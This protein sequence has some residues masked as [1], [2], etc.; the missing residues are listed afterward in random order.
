MKRNTWI[1]LA[2]FAAL[3]GLWA[4]KNHKTAPKSPPALSID[5]YIGNVSEQD[6][7]TQAKDKPSPVTHIEIARKDDKV[8]LDRLQV[9]KPQEPQQG[10][11]PAVPAVEAKWKVVRTY[12][13][14]TTETTA[15][16]FR[17]QSM[18]ETLQRSIRSTYG[19]PVQAAQLADYGLD[20]DHALVLTL[21]LAD[22]KIALKIG[23]LDK[24]QDVDS[25]VTWVQDPARPD[26]AY[27][28]VGRDLRTSFDVTWS[29]LRDRT[30]L[31]LEPAAVD[32]LEIHN[33]ADSQAKSVVV[34]RLGLTDD[35]KKALAEGKPAREPG[36]GWAWQ[37]PAGFQVGE[38][39]EWLKAVDRMS[40]EEFLD[41]ADVLE[42]K[43]DTGLTD[44]AIAVRLVIGIAGQN[45]EVVLG[46]KDEKGRYFGQVKGRDEVMLLPAY[47]R[48]QVVQTVAQLR[49][50]RA[51]AS[52]K[53]ADVTGFSLIGADGEIH[54]ELQGKSW[55]VGKVAVVDDKAV[56][57]YLTDLEGIKV[58]FAEPATPSAVGV[59]PP[60]L[61]VD[62]QSHNGPIRLDFGKEIDNNTWG[63]RTMA[64]RTEWFKVASWGIKRLQKKSEDFADKH[65]SAIVVDK[66]SEIWVSSA[67]GQTTHARKDE[68]GAWQLQDALAGKAGKAESIQGVLDAVHGLQWS[69]AQ[70]GTAITEAG[71]DKDFSGVRWAT[72]DGGHG[73]LRVSKKKFGDEFFVSAGPGRP[74]YTATA[75]AVAALNKKPADFQP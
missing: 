4:V 38:I 35:Q 39:G 6:A 1:V 48:D 31:V 8:V 56:Q 10:D 30:V 62:V 14:K 3:A 18:A 65:V 58:E 57:T 41:P 17:A 13:G 71:L 43:L 21:H 9:A 61:R 46:K 75:A 74:V 54:A 23:Q 27:Q 36:D 47:T 59:Q 69:K 15:Q 2:V 50:R 72:V 33:P 32:R 16:A 29:E 19:V 64:G 68:A 25:S 34:T 53:A 63:Q 73:E 22:R 28:I 60:A 70:P 20:V 5:G 42:K 24:G 40:A 26:V 44:P 11:K 45:T 37:E 51:L 49:D 52:N 7:R 12:K 67:D 66:V 55:S